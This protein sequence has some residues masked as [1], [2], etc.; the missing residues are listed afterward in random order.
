[1]FGF[2]NQVGPLAIPMAII[3]LLTVVKFIKLASSLFGASPAADTDISGIKTLGNLAL[4]LGA[5]STLLGVYQGLQIFHMLTTEQIASGL[6]MALPAILLGLV[7]YIISLILW[8]VLSV[9]V[10]KLGS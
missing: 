5:F 3:A 8:F 9:R 4:A 1:M 6:S 10:C 2:L 7:I